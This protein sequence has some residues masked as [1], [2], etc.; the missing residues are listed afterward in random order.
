ML[1]VLFQ[2]GA[3]RYAISCS[4]V[5]EI[6]PLV[7]LK[8]VPHAPPYVAGVFNFRSMV[9]PVVDLCQLTQH[10]PSNLHLS[11]RIILVN[12]RPQGGENSELRVLGLLAERVT[13]VRETPH[14]S[15]APPVRIASAPYLDK[16]YS[17]EGELVQSLDPSALLSAELREMLFAE[18][19]AAIGQVLA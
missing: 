4:C 14:A 9:V 2:L 1:M 7:S 15:S 13:E 8:T 16:I 5:V 11:S 3:D 12:Y 17:L 19:T 10:R 18:K 6:V